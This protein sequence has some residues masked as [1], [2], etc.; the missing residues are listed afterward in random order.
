[1]SGQDQ[2]G[3]EPETPDRPDY[4]SRPLP[5]KAEITT[6]HKTTVCPHCHHKYSEKWQDEFKKLAKKLLKS[7]RDDEKLRREH[8]EKTEKTLNARNCVKK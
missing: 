1:M 7:A 2:T 6:D 5:Q 4:R 8:H 3:N